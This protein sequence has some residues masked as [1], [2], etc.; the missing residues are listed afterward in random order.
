[1]A[2]NF[3][4][5]AASYCGDRN[6]EIRLCTFNCR[7]VKRSFAEVQQL[8]DG[9]DL[10]L[11]QEHWLLPD[12]LQILSNIHV[13]FL[14][15]GSSAVDI[16]RNL[17]TGRPYGGTAILY[18]K[19]LVDRITVI[20]CVDPRLAAIKLYTCRGPALVLNVYMPTDYHDDDSLEQYDETCGK[21][22]ALITD[23]DV[24]EIILAGDFNCSVGSR[25][26]T[27]LSHLID[28][29]KLVFSD[30]SRLT[31][32]FTYSRDDDSCVSWIDHIVCSSFIDSVVSRLQILY[33]YMLSDHKP[34]SLTLTDILD[35]ILVEQPVLAAS[36]S[37]RHCWDEIDDLTK[38]H[39]SSYV[40]QLLYNV[41]LPYELQCCL[42]SGGRCD[43]SRHCIRVADYYRTVLSAV[44]YAIDAAIPYKKHADSK[45]NVPG[46]NDYPREM[47]SDA[48]N[49]YLEWSYAG[50][51]RFGFLFQHM[52]R[53]RA[54]FKLAFRYCRQN[55]LQLRADACAA[56]L[57]AK[58]PVRFWR[59]VKRI[60]N[61]KATKCVSNIGGVTGEHNV[62]EMWKDH[63]AQL[64]NSVDCD[65]DIKLFTD[66]LS[67]ASDEKIVLCLAD[68]VEAI[69]K[70]K[71][72]KSPGPD[73]I[74]SEA[75]LYGGLR[76]AI[77]LC[78]LFNLFIVHGV[79][80]DS[81]MSSTIVP[82]IKCKTGDLADIN[83]YRAITLSNAIT[84]I[85][86]TIFL[87]FVKDKSA[88]VECQ[89]G[90]KAGHSTALCTY[91][92]K[93]IVD[94]YTSRG[95]HVFVCF[96]DFTKAFDRVNY[97]K[98]FKQLLEDGLSQWIVS[99]LA[100]WYSHQRV[101]VQWHN[102]VSSSFFIG[103]G[104]KQGGILSPCLFNSYI[105]RLILSLTAMNIGCNIGGAIMN[106]FA[107]ADDVVLLAP[108]WFA[109]QQLIKA[110]EQSAFAI[111]MKCNSNKTVCMVFPPKDKRKIVAAVFPY[112][113]LN[114]VALEF[115]TEFKYLGHII[116]NDSRDDKDVMREIRLLFMRTNILNRR[117]GMCS[118]AVKITL[119]RSFCLC[120]YGMALW[121]K[122]TAAS[123]A[124]LRSC[125]NK[126]LKQFF[127]YSKFHSVTSMLID[128][129]MPCFDTVIINSHVAFSTQLESCCNGSIAHLRQLS[130]D[131]YF[132]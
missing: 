86:E 125:Y 113:M 7:S 117:F 3:A 48:R 105:S 60:S 77:H 28:E 104:T 59:S 95:S 43:D 96:A 132:V 130:A 87:E 68:V 123:I 74:S 79:L 93:Y 109:L 19:S 112:F 111:D 80:P 110:L 120:F 99:L 12:E 90:F 58:D 16:S 30:I 23:S 21:I 72:G 91:S 49:A 4:F 126:C 62:A 119:F 129:G 54:K 9:H 89:F 18:R 51:P 100:F 41:K 47:H 20:P 116:C 22:N 114:N 46:W 101:S 29:N 2:S 55:D 108:S 71:K 88:K 38:F 26:Y 107:Y 73:N 76:L 67:L 69:Q 45:Y 8:C 25:F 97:W 31:S 33:E 14:A 50:K 127:G 39:Y 81:F 32:G 13:D 98:L 84:K 10:V 11:L 83:N 118:I 75:Y 115:V 27:T 103:N 17:L 124:R 52:Q 78:N 82:L 36:V 122:Y 92:L 34:I 121:T 94:Y 65:D 85:L 44:E 35:T 70:Q 37:T 66:S 5:S 15:W 57:T 64:Y 24:T 61:G 56:N 128:L 53:T 1:M 42:A 131:F 40:D 6:R 106:I 102:I 63:F